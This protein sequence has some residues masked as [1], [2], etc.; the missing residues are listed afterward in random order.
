MSHSLFFDSPEAYSRDYNFTKYAVDDYT[1]YLHKLTGEPIESL[2][3]TVQQALK[4]DNELKLINPTISYLERMENGDREVIEEPFSVFLKKVEQRNLIMSPSMICY[5]HTDDNP[6]ELA[7]STQNRLDL[8]DSDKSQQKKAKAVNNIPE[9]L[10]YFGSQTSRKVSVNSISGA[11]LSPHNAY[12]NKSAH[13]TMTSMCRI[14]TAYASAN[15]ERLLGGN[16]H[17]DSIAKA[18]ENIVNV[19]NLI[20]LNN[21]QAAIDEY[22]LHIVTVEEM[23]VAILRSTRMYLNSQEGER[24]IYRLVKS[25]TP[26]ERTAWTYCGDLYHFT[27][28][29]DNWTRQLIHDAINPDYTV[30][31]YGIGDA[32]NIIKNMPSSV[33]ELAAVIGQ[34]LFSDPNLLN[35]K[36]EVT[37]YDLGGLKDQRPERYIMFAQIVINVCAAFQ[38]RKTFIDAFLK[39]EC[40]PAYVGYLPTMMRRVVLGSDTDSS[41]ATG[42]HWTKWYT[43]TT[44]FDELASKVLAVM[45]YLTS[46]TLVHYLAQ[47]SANVNVAKRHLYRTAMK[48]EFMYEVY[49][50]ST[51]SKHYYSYVKVC[52][53]VVYLKPEFDVKGVQLIAGKLPKKMRDRLEAMQRDILE[54]I[55]RGELLPLR[56]YVQQVADYE[57]EILEG[58]II[59]DCSNLKLVKIKTEEEYSNPKSQEWFYHDLY[60]SVFAPKYGAAPPLPYMGVSLTISVN[61]QTQFKDWL[62]KVEDPRIRD[63]IVNHWRKWEKAMDKLARIILP[64]DNVKATG[65]PVEILTATSEREITLRTMQPFYLTLESIGFYLYRDANQRITLASD[66]ML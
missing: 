47:F 61:N 27:K 32:Q 63:G 25:L 52:E 62:S 6:S 11:T 7:I 1:L 66:Y 56:K 36:G 40:A 57:K 48:N 12:Y 41:M 64:V 18:M 45:V 34:D 31:V 9:F 15:N 8:R 16:R 5:D 23:M 33:F 13:T 26:L 29:N 59:G 37:T 42:Q 14:T 19:I 2:R 60:E 46:E 38:K 4:N 10:F 43:G 28:Y 53:G 39:N 30:E 24:E 22:N 35:E 54:T 55:G 51:A 17:F 3:T 21:V 44:K 20:D 58:L 50:R 65:I 49:I